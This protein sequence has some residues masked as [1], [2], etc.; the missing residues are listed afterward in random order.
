MDSRSM[1]SRK[2]YSAIVVVCA[3]KKSIH[4]TVTVLLVGVRLPLL[5]TVGD[6]DDDDDDDSA[7]GPVVVT[8]ALVV[9]GGDT[10]LMGEDTGF[11]L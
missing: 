3:H 7:V 5:M 8:A 11:L 6:D 1:D 2:Q 10:P 4:Y 9:D